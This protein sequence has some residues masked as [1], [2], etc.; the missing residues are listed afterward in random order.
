M[1]FQHPLDLST[2]YS[3][4]RNLAGREYSCEIHA[5]D[6]NVGTMKLLALSD[7]VKELRKKMDPTNPWSTDAQEL[8]RKLKEVCLDDLLRVSFSYGKSWQPS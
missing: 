5:A 3:Y 2:A 8:P 4:E 1:T 7:I 6:M